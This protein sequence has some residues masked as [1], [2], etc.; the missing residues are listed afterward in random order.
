MNV[1][2]STRYALLSCATAVILASCST[3]QSSVAPAAAS[4]AQTQAGGTAPLGRMKGIPT[5]AARPPAKHRS[6]RGKSWISPDAAG[7]PRLLYIS[8]YGADDVD[9]F[10]LPKMTLKGSITGLSFPEGECSDAS[11][12]IWIANTGAQEMLQYSRTGT[13]LKT[14]SIANEYPAGCA[15]NKA[16]NDLAVTNI[17]SVSGPGDLMIFKNG[18][19]S[20]TT[21]TDADIYEYFF[22]G[23]D[24]SGNLFFDGTNSDRSAS[25]LAELPSGSSSPKTISLSNGTLYLAGFVQWYRV[26]NY[27]ALGDQGCGGTT[28]SCIYWVSVSGSTGSITGTTT[29]SNYQGGTVCD[30]VEGVI[31]TNGEKY[32]AGPDYESCGY[33]ASTADRW[34]YEAG[35]MPTNYNSSASFVEPIGGAVSTK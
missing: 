16:T 17:V 29:L 13:L 8:D 24:N 28:S 31:G 20:G 1:V 12:N 14:L 27:L 32:V 2:I 25:F 19:G 35:G 21:Y 23:Y 22:A 34:A 18:S 15:V 11:G 10:S 6:N 33:T 30:L 26:G 9:I 4:P 7:L 3:T 5:L